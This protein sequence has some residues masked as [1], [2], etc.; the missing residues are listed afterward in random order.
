V[1]SASSTNLSISRYVLLP[2]R[3]LRG[4][5]PLVSTAARHFLGNLAP[6]AVPT[7][8]TPS[9]HF[10]VVDS[11]S[12]TGAKLVELSP[13]ALNQI[14]VQQPGLRIV[15]VQYYTPAVKRPPEVR[16]Q[17]AAFV[18]AATIMSV[19][20]TNI[21]IVD[22]NT[23]SPV[24]NALV[25]AFTNFAA[26]AGAQGT[27][28]AQ[29]DVSLSLGS[30]STQTDRLYVYP[31][32]GYWPLLKQNVTLSTGVTLELTPI[33]LSFQDGL[34]FFYPLG[35]FTDGNGVTVGVVDTGIAP[36][37]DL[38]IAGGFNAVSGE[39]PNDFG[40]NGEGHGTHVAGIIA[41]HGTPPTGIQGMAPGVTLRSYRVFGQGQPG[42]DNFTIAKAIDQA[43]QDGCDLLNLSLGGGPSDQVLQSAIDDAR[44]AG[45]LVICAAGND[46]RSPV[47]FP[48]SYQLSL[49]VS[50]L[51]REGTYPSGAEEFG[52]I[53]R[54]PSGTASQNYI[55]SFSNVGAQLAF[56]A[57]GDGI[58]STFP[59][60]YAVLDGTSMACPAATGRAALLLANAPT[61][62]G[63]PRDVNRSDALASALLQAAQSL[64]FGHDFE[65]NGLLP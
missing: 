9:G 50:A 53:Q 48:G 62:A 17:A 12:P 20:P 63:M 18:A 47:S 59:G 4:N 23:G 2:P 35:Q 55:T 40:D 37:P 31:K 54:P 39:N 19:G 29:G 44:Q 21:R 60:G 28:D 65:G 51:G 11:I 13:D 58:I 22:G 64:G 7:P 34:R 49:A 33:E 56:T 16:I 57:P 45:C 32:L 1:I 52:N 3:G 24:P 41:A 6:T 61:I 25:V 46:N 30:S 36:H 8:V 15:P 5:S 26:R 14:Q 27:T 38:T 43:I 10:R 42:A